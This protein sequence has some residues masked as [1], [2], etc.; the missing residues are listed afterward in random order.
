MLTSCPAAA[1]GAQL[2]DAQKP[3]YCAA[4]VAFATR[5]ASPW[6]ELPRAKKLQLLW[7]QQLYLFPALK[8]HRFFGTLEAAF[9]TLRE[10]ESTDHLVK[11]PDFVRTLSMALA[12]INVPKPL[13]T[14]QW[15]QWGKLG[16]QVWMVYYGL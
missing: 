15:L 5:E 13:P 12:A 14:S 2:P 7:E 16:R 11:A 1:Q 4:F 10:A 8:E 9:H 3:L 6:S